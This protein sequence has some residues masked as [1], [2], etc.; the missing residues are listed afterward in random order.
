[1]SSLLCNFVAENNM[2]PIKT[3]V[4]TKLGNLF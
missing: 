3:L 1:M 2:S 4:L